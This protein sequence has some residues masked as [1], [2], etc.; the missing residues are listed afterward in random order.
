MALKNN[1]AVDRVAFVLRSADVDADGQVSNNL[2]A[3]LLGAF[4]WNSASS[5][6][7]FGLGLESVGIFSSVQLGIALP[8]PNSPNPC[9]IEAVPGPY[10][11]T[12]GTIVMDYGLNISANSSKSVTVAY[13]GF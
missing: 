9:N 7:P 1:T 5:D 6:H 3:T 8:T 4:G 11:A 2:D 13:R 12:D 10:T